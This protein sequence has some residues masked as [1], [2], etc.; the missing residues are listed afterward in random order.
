[1]GCQRIRADSHAAARGRRL[2]P[3]AELRQIGPWVFF[4]HFGPKLFTAGDGVDVIP[5]PHINLATVTY[6]FDG[7]IVHRDSIGSVREII[8]GAINLMVAGRGI[9]H[10]ER[11]GA[12]RRARSHSIHGLQLWCALPESAEEDAPSFTHYP[13]SEI[14][15]GESCGV[16]AKVLIGEAFGVASPVRTYTRTLL[17][18]ATLDAGAQMRLDPAVGDRAAYIVSGAIECGDRAFGAEHLAV[19]GSGEV[20]LRA[21]EASQI[22]LLGGEPLGERFMWWNFVSSRRERIERAKEEWRLGA[23]PDVPGDDERHPLPERDD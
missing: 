15:Y 13:A 7:A 14:P 3:G 10:S 22:V 5:H 18:E 23:I 11:T 8:P 21:T 19:F 20:T 9:A 2:I 4:D 17:A 16:E 6:L 1:M 12:Q